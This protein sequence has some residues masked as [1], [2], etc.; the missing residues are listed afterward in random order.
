M[1]SAASSLFDYM[2]TDVPNPFTMPQIFP[3]G[4]PAYF[5]VPQQPASAGSAALLAT[6]MVGGHAPPAPVQ[7]YGGFASLPVSP[8]WDTTSLAALHSA[9]SPAALG[10]WTWA[11]PRT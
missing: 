5:T 11:P 10:T 9:P 4:H 6:P 2:Y 3:A 1:S 7:P 8:P